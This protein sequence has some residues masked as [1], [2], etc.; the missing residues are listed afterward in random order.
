MR[1]AGRPGVAP[2]ALDQLRR[3]RAEALVMTAVGIV[4]GAVLTSAALVA[5]S[6]D[7]PP[8]IALPSIASPGPALL[9]GDRAEP[10]SAVL[11]QAVDDVTI[12]LRN[13]SWLALGVAAFS[14]VVGFA[15]QSGR[16]HRELGIRRA[17]GAP[18]VVLRDAISLESLGLGGIALLAG[19][20]LG[21]AI[22]I[23]AVAAW[24]GHARLSPSVAVLML[25][26]APVA[27]AFLAASRAAF[28]RFLPATM[29]MTPSEEVGIAV[30]MIQLAATVAV[31]LATAALVAP[32]RAE[33]VR[34]SESATDLVLEVDSGISDPAERARRYGQ[35]LREMSME[36][37]S[38]ARLQS[39]GAILGI[40]AVNT[41]TA[42][43]G[44]CYIGGLIVRYQGFRTVTH[45]VSARAIDSGR[46]RL[47]TGRGFTSNDTLGAAR[48]A[49]V[50]RFAALKYFEGGRAVG[51]RI[52]LEVAGR[53]RAY[54]VISVVDEAPAETMAGMLQPWSTVY[55]SVLQHPPRE[56]TLVRSAQAT[57]TGSDAVRARIVDALGP[58]ATIR[59][60]TSTT[61]L[62][63][64]ERRTVRWVGWATTTTGVLV[65]LCALAGT[66]LAVAA[67][68]RSML[69]EMALRRSVGARRRDIRRMILLRTAAIAL[70]GVLLGA[71]GYLLV[72]GPALDRVIPQLQ[73]PMLG[74]SVPLVAAVVLAVLVASTVAG[75]RVA[76]KHPPATL[77]HS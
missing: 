46:T 15:A 52:F 66:V 48:V 18:I 55:L 32:P 6:G 39:A 10:P 24:P 53:S 9:L 45:A 19:T 28:V 70:G 14:I 4:G 25:S 73:P 23:V 11:R 51:R 72:L 7:Q 40:G 21:A 68:A 12:L 64:E 41:V 22:A 65:F 57:Q 71:Y 31:L 29:T 76:L 38:D 47:L 2:T 8:A 5:P 33:A 37:G 61:E 42:D 16:R 26:V 74:L 13:L 27:I 77:L 60:V 69:F 44:R 50:N 75:T 43:C 62:R 67:W 54:T 35:M 63:D 56:V 3:Y 30:P 34:P 59:R 36:T 49:V 20:A 1:I 58:A 17:V